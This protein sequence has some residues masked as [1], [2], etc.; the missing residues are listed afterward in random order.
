MGPMYQA[1]IAAILERQRR[2][3]SAGL[4]AAVGG[5]MASS[6]DGGVGAALGAMASERAPGGNIGASVGGMVPPAQRKVQPTMVQSP[7]QPRMLPQQAPP[8]PQMADQQVDLEGAL[9]RIALR[10]LLG[11]G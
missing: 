4:G 3:S 9:T 11:V 5:D 2:G 1:M 7:A 6:A 10:R 8:N